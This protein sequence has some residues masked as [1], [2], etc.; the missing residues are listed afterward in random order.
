MNENRIAGCS[1]HLVIYKRGHWPEANNDYVMETQ[2]VLSPARNIDQIKWNANL[3]ALQFWRG[4]IN[5]VIDADKNAGWTLLCLQNGWLNSVKAC[6]ERGHKQ[7]V[8]AVSSR[9]FIF[10][11]RFWSDSCARSWFQLNKHGTRR[12]AAVSDGSQ[13]R[14]LA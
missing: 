11:L 13:A 4:G 6:G 1:L 5:T 14:P 10:L 9:F 2:I 7:I 8:T 3:Y 12:P